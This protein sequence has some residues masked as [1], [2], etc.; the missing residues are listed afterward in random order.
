M[1]RRMPMQSGRASYI[2][3]RTED[4]DLL[5]TGTAIRARRCFSIA[6]R[7][8]CGSPSTLHCFDRS[9]PVLAAALPRLPAPECPAYMQ[10]F[11]FH[12]AAIFC[13]RRATE[14]PSDSRATLGKESCT[15]WGSGAAQ[16]VKTISDYNCCRA[17]RRDSIFDDR[18]HRSQHRGA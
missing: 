2:G 11:G 16:T 1:H 18:Y 13:Q 15:S 14:P 10:N 17:S 5:S 12:A 6:A 9:A 8:A 7:T 3:L 4:A